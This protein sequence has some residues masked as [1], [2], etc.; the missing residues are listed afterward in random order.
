MLLNP[1]KL[2]CLLLVLPLLTIIASAQPV[3]QATGGYGHTMFIKSDGSLWVM[4]YD[5][6]GQLGDGAPM[7]STNRPERIAATNVTAIA[8]GEFDSLFVANGALWDMGYN[9]SYGALGNGSSA[10]E[11]TPIMIVPN[12][13][14]AVV[15]GQQFNV[16]LKK[17]GSL[18]GMGYNGDGQLGDGSNDH[19]NF[20][21]NSPEEIVSSGVTSIAAGDFH[22]LFIKNDGSLWAMGYDTYGELGDGAFNTNILTGTNR[23]EEIVS[24]GVTAIAGGE[25]HSLFLK[26][27]G[28]LWAMG[29]NQYG[30][31]GDGT[32]NNVNVPEM[33]VPSN[34]VAIAAGEGHSLFLKSD[35]SVWGMGDNYYG[36]LAGGNG[37]NRP[38]ELIS[39]KVTAIG[40]GYLHSLFVKT[41]G[42]LWAVGSD[43][44]G[45]LGDN[46]TYA[47][48]STTNGTHQIE[49]ILGPYNQIA[50]PQPNGNAVQLPF[51]GIAGTNYA[52]D[53]C[54]N[55]LARNWIPQTT[56]P[57][58]SYGP[59]VFTNTLTP[60]TNNFWRVRLVP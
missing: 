10:T 11:T 32:T 39:G 25:Y 12:N 14:S 59:M 37:T 15:A 38:E 21:T 53:H 52:L 55:L 2:I 6:D 57:A 13:V 9:G 28:S 48:F 16:F 42:S 43:I 56:N 50:T 19:G 18:W 41:G 26:S 22:T 3:T 46:V 7:Q 17:D 20:Y 51:V 34:V 35:G 5:Q 23:P 40:A 44:Y 54:V 27:N 31:L 4:G 60:G 24:S 30:Q 47:T 45:E 33:I 29:W 58:S 49:Q 36:Q 8:A 1:F